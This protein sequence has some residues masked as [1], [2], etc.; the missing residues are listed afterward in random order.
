MIYEIRRVR[1]TG[2]SRV[3]MVCW[4]EEDSAL[5]LLGRGAVAAATV[6]LL[7]FLAALLLGCHLLR[8]FSSSIDEGV[9]IA[10][11][12]PVRRFC[13]RSHQRSLSTSPARVR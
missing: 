3:G 4:H 5:D 10:T 11:P 1:L 6:A 9:A 13:G 7:A 12:K 8:G 2:A